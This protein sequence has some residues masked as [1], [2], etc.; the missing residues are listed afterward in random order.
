MELCANL[1]T[2]KRRL[3]LR[4]LQILTVKVVVNV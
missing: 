2:F 1:C 3:E 4:L